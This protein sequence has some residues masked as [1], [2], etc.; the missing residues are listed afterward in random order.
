MKRFL[1]SVSF[2]FGP[3]TIGV[4]WYGSWLDG[5]DFCPRHMTCAQ[6][7][8][9][10]RAAPASQNGDMGRPVAVRRGCEFCQKVICN[11]AHFSL[12][13]RCDFLLILA[14]ATAS[15]IFGNSNIISHMKMKRRWGGKFPSH[16]I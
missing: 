5:R 6:R 7:A 3:S 4:L 10:N 12:F 9:S 15:V 14:A 16:A 13:S 8:C 2:C 1:V 11:T